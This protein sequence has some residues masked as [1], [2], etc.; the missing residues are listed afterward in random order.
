MS[1]NRE[2][3][4]RVLAGHTTTFTATDGTG[5]DVRLKIDADG[6]PEILS[7]EPEPTEAH[8]AEIDEYF[9]GRLSFQHVGD[10][11]H[12]AI[13]DALADYGD[14]RCHAQRDGD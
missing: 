9:Y 8:D 6:D 13:E 11:F 4:N 10:I 7:V 14:V 1:N 2:I 5:Y 3:A 12:D